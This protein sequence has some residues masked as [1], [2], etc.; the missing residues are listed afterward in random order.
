MIFRLVLCGEKYVYHED[1]GENISP[2]N[3]YLRAPWIPG[4]NRQCGA[5]KL[6]E[7]K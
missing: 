7:V 3:L 1:H 4:C 2:P 5:I 6:I